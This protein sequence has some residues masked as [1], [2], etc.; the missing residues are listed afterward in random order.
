M[1]KPK[2]ILTVGCS[3]SGKSTYAKELVKEGFIQVER[4]LIRRCLFPE[5]FFNES[6]SGYKF[7]RHKESLVTNEANRLIE[8]A[9]NDGRSVVVSDTNINPR[10]RN[11]LISF[12]NSI[13]FQVEQKFIYAQYNDLLERNKGRPYEV[14]VKVISN[15]WD[16]LVNQGFIEPSD[17]ES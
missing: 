12:L 14:P 1:N 4:D 16:S 17:L 9:F 13:G 2:A 7:N 3:A 5:A 10:F 15:Q 6:W 11:R 8:K